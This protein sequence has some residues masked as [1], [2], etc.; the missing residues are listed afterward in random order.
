MELGYLNKRKFTSS[1]PS[2]YVERSGKDLNTSLTLRTRN[3]PK[4]KQKA[5]VAA[6]DVCIEIFVT[7]I[8]E[9]KDITYSTIGR[10]F[11]GFKH[12]CLSF[13]VYM[14]VRVLPN[15]DRL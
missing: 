6:T 12:Y 10:L 11:I 1:G 14:C 2:N 5:I 3:R 15:Y 8:E 13:G 9:F 4:S 7:I